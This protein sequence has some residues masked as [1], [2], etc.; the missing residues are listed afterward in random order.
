MF[1]YCSAV[2]GDWSEWSAWSTCSPDCEQTRRRACDRP[3][4]AGGGHYC[5]G[6]DHEKTECGGGACPRET[7]AGGGVWMEPSLAAAA[8]EEEDGPSDRVEAPAAAGGLGSHEVALYVGLSLAVLVF[9]LVVLVAASL[10]RRR[11]LPHGHTLSQ[12]GNN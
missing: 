1:S 10:V 9:M 7:A 4:P 3:A 11:R 6:L 2:N 8:G 5:F 12:S